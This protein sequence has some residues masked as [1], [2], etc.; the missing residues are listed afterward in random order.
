MTE[1]AEILHT[2]L[3]MAS[4][5]L[6]VA[7][8]LQR[9]AAN[10]NNEFH[11]MNY[12]A[13]GG[14]VADDTAAYLAACAAAV[15][16]GGCA[17]VV[18][19]ENTPI[20]I[21]QGYLFTTSILTA[22]HSVT[23]KGAGQSESV[24][25]WDPISDGDYLARWYTSG[26]YYA[27]GGAERLFI[28]CASATAT[29]PV[30]HV[31][32]T[33]MTR[34]SDVGI[35]GYG[36]SG[37]TGLLCDTEGPITQHL[38]LN[39]VMIQGL[40]VGIDIDGVA[41]MSAYELKL[42]QNTVAQGILRNATLSWYGGL[43]QGG[44]ASFEFRPTDEGGVEF[45]AYGLWCEVTGSVNTFKAYQATGGFHYGGHISLYNCKNNGSHT[46]ID[47]DKYTVHI[48]NLTQASVVPVIAALD[49]SMFGVN[50]TPDATKYT[51]DTLTQPRVTWLSHGNVSVGTPGP[52]TAYVSSKS[53]NFGLPIQL[54]S[55]TPTQR[56]A[57]SNI[58]E[59]DHVYNNV[60]KVPQ[61][62]NGTKW[63]SYRE[64]KAVDLLGATLLAE[65]DARIG[66]GSNVWADGITGRVLTGTGSPTLAV[67]GG[68][69]GGR[70]VWKF[71]AASSQSM[72]TGGSGATLFA[73]GVGAYYISFVA[74]QSSATD[75]GA[76]QGYVNTLDNA[77]TTITQQFSRV[78]SSTVWNS[79]QV[80]T[81]AHSGGATVD[82]NPHLFEIYLNA[83]GKRCFA[84]D[85]VE[86]GD[87]ATGVVTATIVQRLMIGAYPGAS[88]YSNVNIARVRICT[89]LPSTALR[90]TLYEIDRDVWSF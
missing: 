4:H 13:V 49:S 79:Y 53:A 19:P 87:G 9:R 82:L 8:Y 17:S 83:S 61:F 33:Y 47:V 48:E 29:G 24:V 88:F 3:E 81:L 2:S 40:D 52:T 65:W 59:N 20:R 74:R 89:T 11:V 77:N 37:G 70:N 1:L 28:K 63:R 36:S 43:I 22:L 38:V 45:C 12:G 76:T 84:V 18:F 60:A 58:A 66:T 86:Y 56:D 35:F 78:A 75:T 39:N 30:F 31:T 6:Q 68:Y 51:F 23:L 46:Y 34:F 21:R 14:G 15:T 42:N 72:D 69:F 16:A 27:G 7:T 71:V 62:Y 85:G 64:P 41:A 57:L 26:N 73:A 25:I 5:K 54:A 32:D 90:A 80:G 50:L 67:D 10:T 44:G 55:V